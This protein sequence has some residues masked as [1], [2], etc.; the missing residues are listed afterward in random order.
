MQFFYVVFASYGSQVLG[1]IM[2]TLYIYSI[3]NVNF[4]LQYDVETILT[5][6]KN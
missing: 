1:L 4:V 6:I 2:D 5:T 3:K